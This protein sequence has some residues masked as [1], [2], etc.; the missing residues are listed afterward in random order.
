M[1]LVRLI[2]ASLFLVAV[3][4]C[5]FKPIWD[6]EGKWK[7][8]D[9][10]QVIEFLQKGRVKIYNNSSVYE[11][12]YSF[13]DKN[14]FKI[15]FG[16]LG[17]IKV[18]FKVSGKELTI[19]NPEGKTI[20]FKKIVGKEPSETHKKLETEVKSEKEHR[21]VPVEEKEKMEGEHGPEHQG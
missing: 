14:H 18:A 15:S 7:Q 5:S 12:N 20:R 9:G 17:A 8:V 11:A 1:K 13:V 19:T 21:K 4:S 6:L 2:V 10:N 3:F 16:D